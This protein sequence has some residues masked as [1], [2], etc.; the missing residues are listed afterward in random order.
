LPSALSR[1]NAWIDS[2]FFHTSLS[3]GQSVAGFDAGGTD[4]PFVGAGF[5]AGG[6]GVPFVGA[7]FD[8]GGTGVSFS[9]PFGYFGSIPALAVA[10]ALFDRS[11]SAAASPHIRGSASTPS[12]NILPVSFTHSFCAFTLPVES[13]IWPLVKA[14]HLVAIAFFAIF[15]GTLGLRLWPG[16]GFFTRPRGWVPPNG[17]SLPF[18]LILSIIKLSPFVKT[19]N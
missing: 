4:V 11:C 18:V 9:V 14:P 13:Y 10:I 3:F 15:L 12:K 19:N 7:G 16:W 1:I 6:T 2:S 5:D 17:T 8:A